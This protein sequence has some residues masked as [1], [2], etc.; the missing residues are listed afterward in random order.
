MLCVT[1]V[2]RTSDDT[3]VV[4]L[5]LSTGSGSLLPGDVPH[6]VRRSHSD[7][8]LADGEELRAADTDP[9]R[10]GQSGQ[11]QLGDEEEEEEEEE[12]QGGQREEG[13]ERRLLG[14]RGHVHDRHQL[15]RRGG[16]G[17]QQVRK[18]KGRAVWI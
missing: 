7:E 18:Y 14:G 11:R 15:G 1:V 6:P 12:G 2:R 9:G 8:L 16:D 10:L 4:S 17:D 5:L 3:P 13:G